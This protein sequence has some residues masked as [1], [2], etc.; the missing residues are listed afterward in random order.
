MTTL[1]RDVFAHEQL[2]STRTQNGADHRFDAR[3]RPAL[4]KHRINC[5]INVTLTLDHTFNNNSAEEFCFGRLSCV[6]AFD[7]AS[8]ANAF[9]NP[10][11]TRPIGLPE[12]PISYSRLNSPS[13]AAI[14]THHATSDQTFPAIARFLIRNTV[15]AASAAPPPLFISLRE[16][17]PKPALH[18][19]PSKCHCRAANRRQPTNP[20]AHA[21]FHLPQ[22]QNGMSRRQIR[23]TRRNSRIIRLTLS[24]T[25]LRS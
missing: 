17:G 14:V 4:G 20:S 2:I 22:Y 11:T 16:R 3:K 15:I 23:A 5:K 13:R 10:G 9:S 12:I 18:S 24:G 8:R 1:T 25:R 21:S 6:E 7:P 19:R